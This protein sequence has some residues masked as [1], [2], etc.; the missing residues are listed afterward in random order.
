MLKIERTVNGEVVLRGER[1]T[2]N[3]DAEGAI[4]LYSRWRLRLGPR[5]S[6]TEQILL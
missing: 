4:Q 6:G 5:H 1:S 3:R 2:R